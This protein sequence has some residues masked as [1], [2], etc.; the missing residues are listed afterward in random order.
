M[1]LVK[2]VID[3]N[4]SKFRN[5]SLKEKDR[6]EG[7]EEGRER[8]RE[9][10]KHLGNSVHKSSTYVCTCQLDLLTLGMNWLAMPT[11]RIE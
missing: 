4:Y 9:K 1:I 3:N 7:R 2:P 10:G 6:E 8:G 11:I 5:Q